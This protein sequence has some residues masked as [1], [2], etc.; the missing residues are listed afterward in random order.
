MESSAFNHAAWNP[1]H[2]IGMQF[3]TLNG[4]HCIQSSCM[5]SPA[6]N[7]DALGHAA[8]PL[9]H[10]LHQLSMAPSWHFRPTVATPQPKP[11]IPNKQMKDSSC[12]C[13]GAL[14]P[15]LTSIRTSSIEV[16]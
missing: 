14:W 5:E 16:H 4:V 7:R 8:R 2:S 3:T 1:L 13:L 6:F 15:L 12:S 11:A 10:Q 9:S